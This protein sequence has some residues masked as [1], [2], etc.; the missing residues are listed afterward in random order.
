MT[1]EIRPAG[2]GYRPEID[3]LR[4]VAVVAVV[5]FHA[6]LA[7]WG[8]GYV[9][10]DVF[11]VISGY[12]IT[13]LLLCD[14]RRGRFS[15]LAFCERRVRR[16]LPALY[17]VLCVTA[18]LAWLMLPPTL[19]RDWAKSLGAALFSV[20]N[21]Y[22]WRSAGYFDL[23]QDER[24]LLHTWSLGVEEQFYLL[25]PALLVLVMRVRPRA[26][27]GVL[28]ALAM[29]SWVAADTLLVSTRSSAAFYLL[30]FRAWELLLGGCLAAAAGTRLDPARVPDRLAQAAAVV[31][32]LMLLGSIVGLNS[33]ARVPGRDALWPVLGTVLLLAF[34]RPDQGVGRWL[35]CAP[36]VAVGQGS[37]SL[38]LWHQPLLALA[39]ILSPGPL[40]PDALTGVLALTLVLAACTW[41]WVEQPAR[42]RQSC[43]TRPLL[44]VLG[45][46]TALLLGVAGAGALTHGMPAR[47]DAVLAQRVASAEPSPRRSAC[48]TRPV[49]QACT[50]PAGRVTWAVLGDSHVVE[51]A[52]ALAER[53]QTRQEAL[54]HLSHSACSPAWSVD[55]VACSG[56][57][58]S[59]VQR[60]ES[61]P[62]IRQVLVGFR[63]AYHLSGDQMADYPAVPQRQR[64]VPGLSAQAYAQALWADHAALLDRLRA[65][66]K[67]VIVLAPVPE[68]GRSIQGH[69]ARQMA[70]RADADQG[71]TR[72]YFE[73]RQSEV[74]AGLARLPWGP[75]LR[76]L[77]P[78]GVFC[79][80]QHCR[81][82]EGDQALYFDDD[83][84]SVAGARRLLRDWPLD[85]PLPADGAGVSAASAARG[86]AA[87]SSAPP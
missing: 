59:A 17:L 87:A 18:V 22:F 4:A 44:A 11:F 67:Q 74:L 85:V 30:P 49:D 5:C 47:L 83:H 56:W 35:A 71:T 7:G 36:V 2:P 32:G 50:Y 72:A 52:Q 10:V 84:L 40:A 25:L 63:L 6:G 79:D 24:L 42:N 51:L 43:R 55:A 13:G 65:A 23:G 70:G 73:Q 60:I 15:L 16:L 80:A 41:R 45:A 53:L 31:G 86:R 21:L 39:R 82:F 38:Y 27:P 26:V 3:G 34:A 28:A 37:Y 57:L 9:G 77:D 46:L 75:G 48:H 58:R 66:G 78:A 1:P 20:S 14:L 29:L 12:L 64:T 62:G 61:D 8:G 68:L 54:L 19:L 33:E 81:A 76:R 69:L